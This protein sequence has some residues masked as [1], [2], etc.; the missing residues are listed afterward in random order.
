[1]IVVATNAT[2]AP[3]RPTCGVSGSPYEG[4]SFSRGVPGLRACTGVPATLFLLTRQRRGP[5]VGVVRRLVTIGGPSWSG[6]LSGGSIF[7]TRRRKP[8]KGK[9]D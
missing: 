7:D 5:A 3:A 4:P 2:D 9:G 6:W 1:M 8:C